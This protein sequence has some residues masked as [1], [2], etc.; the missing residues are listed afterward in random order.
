MSVFQYSILMYVTKQQPVSNVKITPAFVYT[1]SI[2]LVL[3]SNV[4]WTMLKEVLSY[5][6]IAQTKIELLVC[7][8]LLLFAGSD[9]V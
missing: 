4:S 2:T 6:R 5:M 9:P 3:Y 8:Q 7:W 1:V